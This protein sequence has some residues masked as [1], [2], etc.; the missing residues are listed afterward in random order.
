[1]DDSSVCTRSGTRARDYLNGYGP[2]GRY[3]FFNISSPGGVGCRPLKDHPIHE[4]WQTSTS[5]PQNS[6]IR[7]RRGS[8][9]FEET[10]PFRMH[11]T[12]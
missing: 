12:F 4:G 6:F 11:N 2:F 9:D 7:E 8:S 1:V 3:N 5:S 10:A